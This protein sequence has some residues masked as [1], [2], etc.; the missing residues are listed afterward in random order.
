MSPEN[1]ILRFFQWRTVQF[2]VVLAGFIGLVV[3]ATPFGLSAAIKAWFLD[4]G[5]RQVTVGDVT[6]DFLSARF[7]IRGLHVDSEVESDVASDVDAI[8]GALSFRALLAGRI[9]F[10][11]LLIRNARLTVSQASEGAPWRIGGLLLEA[12]PASG[13][14]SEKNSSRVDW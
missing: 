14:V 6:F 1:R 8:E 7:S 10:N 11:R 3:A 2:A 4:R 13:T 5:A 12:P 9:Q